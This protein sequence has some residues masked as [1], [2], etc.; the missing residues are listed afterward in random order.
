[1]TVQERTLLEEKKKWTD[2]INKSKEERKVFEQE[3]ETI[4]KEI[5]SVRQNV[6]I[7]KTKNNIL[8]KKLG[9]YLQ[10]IIDLKSRTEYI[11]SIDPG[12][13]DFGI[14][15]ERQEPKKIESGVFFE[16]TFAK[17]RH[18]KEKSSIFPERQNSH[19]TKSSDHKKN[20]KR[21]NMILQVKLEK[22][23]IIMAEKELLDLL[24]TE[25]YFSLFILHF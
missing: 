22:N 10:K 12:E 19:R 21:D 13:I 1:L 15:T 5:E 18:K 9:E 4:I 23:K 16:G 14:Q 3:K 11:N 25:Y 6:I 24:Q 7:T 20:A 8:E 17:P 2:E